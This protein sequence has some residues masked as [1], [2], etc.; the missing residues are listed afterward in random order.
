M[1]T[2]SQKESIRASL[3]AYVRR[4]P[5][6]NKAVNSLKGTSAGTVSS[7]INGKWENIS[8]DMWL[9]LQ[10]QIRGNGGWTLFSTAAYQGLTL[11]L[12][13]ARVDGS[14]SWITGPAGCGKSTTAAEYA[15]NHSNVYVLTCS[16][17]MTKSD[18]VRELAAKIGIRVAGLTS[19]EALQ[20]IIRE[21][22]KKESPLL[23][24]DEG[25]KL[26]DPVLYY[27][28][29]LYNALEDKCGM[30]FLSTSYMVERMRRGVSR[31]RK[32]Y[33]ELESRICRRFVPLDLVSGD[34]VEGICLANGLTERSAIN[35]VRR[36]AQE[37]GNDLRRVKKS[38]HKELRKLAAAREIE[39]A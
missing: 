33:D 35:A 17:D 14:V 4:Y 29:S 11:Y 3:E 32:G 1:I 6:Q 15:R 16:G 23:V 5:S 12:D 36:E 37:C 31:G 2:N 27:Y 19:R 38:V 9:K 25:D 28:V 26:A 30:V 21:L 22:V 24:F 10:A 8:D 13:D 20:Q 39:N 18:F 34:E 7:I